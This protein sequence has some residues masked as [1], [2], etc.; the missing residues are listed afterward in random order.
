VVNNQA[1]YKIKERSATAVTVEVSID[2]QLLKDRLGAIY[3]RYSREVSIPGF[4]RG[5]VPHSFLETRFGKEVFLQ[6]VR[7][8]LQ[9]EHLPKALVELELSPVS[10]PELKTISAEDDS[11]FVFEASL[12]VLPE[13]ELP[14]YRGIE[15]AVPPEDEVAEE[16]IKAALE[17][18]QRRHATLVPKE[19]KTVSEGD[20]VSVKAGDEEWDMRVSRRHPVTSRLIGNEIGDA[21]EVDLPTSDENVVPAE[22]TI[23]AIKEIELPEMDDELAKDAGYED[24]TTLREGLT[25]EIEERRARQREQDIKVKLLDWVVRQIDLPLPQ[26]LVDQVTA[27]DFTN[28]KKSF[29]HPGS[30]TT[31][32]DY[33]EE[34]GKEEEAM[35]AEYKRRVEE[36]LRRELVLRRIVEKEGLQIDDEQLDAIARKDAEEEGKDPLR[37]VA[38]L[39]AKEQWEDF[40]RAKLNERVLSILYAEAK[41]KEEK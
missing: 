21:V 41:I 6:D 30:T 33:L 10:P 9:K 1:S 18:T 31:F 23:V 14:D 25:D 37:F 3:D 17:E 28:F 5:H 20:I 26:P 4:R 2:K 11:S 19:G 35:R 38:Q 40:R 12:A 8:Q 36:R 7:E 32:A 22:L 39:K 15:L 24:L 34:E 29:D 13:F 27:E 16:D